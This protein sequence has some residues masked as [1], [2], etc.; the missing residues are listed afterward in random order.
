[1]GEHI[2]KRTSQ[3]PFLPIKEYPPTTPG[4]RLRLARYENY[5]TII[6]L[7][8]KTGLTTTTISNLERDKYRAKLSTLRILAQ[9]L[10]TTVAY[11]GCFESLPEETYAQKI[12]KARLYHGL[13]IKE[14]AETLGVDVRTIKNW[15]QN[16]FQPLPKHRESLAAYLAILEI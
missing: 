5:L 11:L 12:K 2:I 3:L 10:E 16:M 4:D 8:E 13:N 7:A 9:T 6:E 15:E 1:M 14:F